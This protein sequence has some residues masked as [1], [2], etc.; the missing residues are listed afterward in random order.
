[1]MV[2]EREMGKKKEAL[3][4][5]VRDPRV[6][7]HHQMNR[8]SRRRLLF[9]SVKHR[10]ETLRPLPLHLFSPLSFQGTMEGENWRDGCASLAPSPHRKL[11]KRTLNGISDRVQSISRLLGGTMRERKALTDGPGKSAFFLLQP[12]MLF[13]VKDILQKICP[14][15]CKRQDTPHLAIYFVTPPFLHIPYSLLP[16]S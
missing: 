6:F 12:E 8:C 15:F 5:L 4:A 7:V 2:Q 9:A 14:P 10:N 13:P 3:L 1:M 16:L 11:P